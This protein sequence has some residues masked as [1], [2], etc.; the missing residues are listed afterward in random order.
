MGTRKLHLGCARSGL[1]RQT[2]KIVGGDLDQKNWE[3]W[4]ESGAMIQK[5]SK[6]FP[7]KELQGVPRSLT[8]LQLEL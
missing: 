3:L 7:A 8:G 4:R 6:K 5:S 1:A 2:K